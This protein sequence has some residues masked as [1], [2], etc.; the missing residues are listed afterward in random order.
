M[1]SS[2]SILS[3]LTSIFE[4]TSFQTSIHAA[5]GNTNSPH[6]N[7]EESENE[8]PMDFIFLFFPDET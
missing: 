8:I 4:V 3:K 5:P 1:L 7:P 2:L 6:D